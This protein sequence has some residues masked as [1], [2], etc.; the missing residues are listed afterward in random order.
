ME[1]LYKGEITVE[2]ILFVLFSIAALLQL[3][4]YLG[5]FSRLG[6]YKNKNTNETSF[7]ASIIICARNEDKNL[8]EFLP[9]VLQQDYPRYEVIVVNDCSYDNTADV[10]KELLQKYSHLKIVTIKEDEN[11]YHGKKFALMVGIKGAQYE[12]LLLTDADCKPNSTDWLK[13]MVA[14][15][16]EETKIVLGYGAYEKTKSFLN[17]LIRFD[18]F[19]AATQYLSFALAHKPY[20]GVGRNL[21]YTKSLFFSNKGFAS[22]YHIESG[23]DD[24]FI[25]EAATKQNA[26]V[27]V[28][29]ESHTVS[30]AKRTLKS[31]MRQKRRHITTFPQYTAS[32]RLRFLTVA[33]S[34]Y[35]FFG[36][37]IALLILQVQPYITLEIFFFRFLI[38]MLIFRKSMVKLGEKDLWWWFPVLE[39]TLLFFYPM[40]AISNLF[41]RKRK[42]KI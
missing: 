10:L 8:A 5:I 27:E 20:M 14:H 35:F 32:S 24:L 31:W 25:N 17:K 30:K 28:A 40:L 34:Q 36:F 21:A 26:K 1:P 12:H 23:D 6:F 42:W 39:I 13:N 38:Q 4:Y 11:H 7:P 37:F 15:F 2:L 19:Y 16:S 9:A 3:W 33:F 29:I 18:T 41:V 22:H